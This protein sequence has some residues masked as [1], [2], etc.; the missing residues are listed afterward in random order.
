MSSHPIADVHRPASSPR[1]PSVDATSLAY[2]RTKRP[3][4]SSVVAAADSAAL[5]IPALV[6]SLPNCPRF[7]VVADGG[8]PSYCGRLNCPVCVRISAL[9]AA[10]AIALAAPHTT[11]RLSLVGGSWA[12][13][14]PRMAGL[15]R[16][17]RRQLRG[18]FQ[19]AWHVEANPAGAGNHIHGWAW[20]H[21]LE[22]A[23]LSEA[24]QNSG[25]GRDV[26]VGPWRVPPSEDPMIAYGLKG[27]L[28]ETS[29]TVLSPATRQFKALNGEALVHA[30]RGFYRDGSAGPSL[31]T[32]REAER[33]A[34]A[35]RTRR[36][37]REAVSA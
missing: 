23:L 6:A 29:T 24:A 32:R 10:R 12:E 14:Q 18:T 31:R 11:Y 15:V 9:K 16:R 21:R 8:R 5:N 4:C 2:Y 27:V 28:A 33:L 26:Y 7:P 34:K 20:G 37:S 36:C 13:I 19:H 22:S 35:R 1:G 17:V 30:S 25:M 3:A